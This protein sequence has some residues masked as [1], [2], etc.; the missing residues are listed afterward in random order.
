MSGG[1]V[2][3]TVTVKLAVP[4]FECASVAVQVTV[5]G[6]NGNSTPDAGEQETGTVPSTTSD[7]DAVNV[8]GAPVALVASF[9]KLAGTLTTGAVVSRTVTVKL[10]E[11]VLPPASCAVQFTVVVPTAKVLPEEGAQL[12]ATLP[13]TLS[14]AEAE[15]V[16]DAPLAP[17]AS[18]V[19]APGTVTTGATPSVTVTLNESLAEF[20]ESSVAVQVTVV[21][22]TGK[23]LPEPFVH[24][25]AGLGSTVSLAETL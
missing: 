8:A 3:R 22:P 16:T 12:V 25:I 11:P 4:V 1:V 19:I 2:S 15:N 17:V 10:F 21:W 5:V 23:V 24:E 6:P 14:L 20:P 9:A 18:C 13:S 7:A